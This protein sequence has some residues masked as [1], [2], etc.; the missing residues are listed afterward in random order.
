M[1]SIDSAMLAQV[2]RVFNFFA[3]RTFAGFKDASELRIFEHHRL[4]MC[5]QLPLLLQLSELYLGHNYVSCKS[6]LAALSSYLQTNCSLKVLH[7]NDNV[8]TDVGCTA[9]AFAL[10]DNTSLRSLNM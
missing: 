6:G 1:R 5:T 10:T 3:W 2:W 4:Q 7:I 9:I 8:L